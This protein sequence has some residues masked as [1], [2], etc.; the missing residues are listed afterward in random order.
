MARL[1]PLSASAQAAAHLRAELERGHWSGMMPGVNQLA[2]ELGVTRKTVEAA[3]RQLE[4]DGLLINQGPGRR[5]LI[6]LP[7][8]V[9]MRPMRVAILLY[10]PTDR[11]LEYIIEL[12][13]ALAEAGHSVVAIAKSLV[14]LNMDVT[15]VSRLVKQTAADAWVVV[16]GSTEVLKWFCAQPRPVFALFGRREGLTIAAMGPDKSEA[17]AAATRHLV[18]LGHRRIVMLCRQLRRLPKPGS[19][20]QAFLDELK[21]HRL[22]ACDYN[23]PDWEETKEGFQ[24]LLRSLFRVTPPTALII[25]EASFF[26]ATQQFLASRVIRVPQQV[27]LI[28]TD[29]DP[30][31]AWCTPAIS[32]IRWDSGPL[33]RRIVRWAATVSRGGMDVKQTS[34]PAEFVIGGT[35]GRAT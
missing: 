19:S 35:I 6:V 9:A 21:A 17:L 16:A 7:N 31:F 1:H 14:E 5:R 22:P 3:L 32:H 11:H 29:A 33:V 2:P 13:H 18:S 26:I 25:D 28:C 12:Q 10:E 30:A 24:K 15:R 8:G 20:E 23:L 34:V 4:H 27:S